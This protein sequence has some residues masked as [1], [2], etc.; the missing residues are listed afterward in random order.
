MLAFSLAPK[1]FKKVTSFAYFF[2]SQRWC[3]ISFP[4]QAFWGSTF[5]C[6]TVLRQ[7]TAVSVL[8]SAVVLGE[9]LAVVILDQR[10]WKLLSLAHG[11]LGSF[12]APEKVCGFA[13]CSNAVCHWGLPSPLS[14]FWWWVLGFFP[15][16]FIWSSQSWSSDLGES[17]SER[18][19]VLVFWWGDG[20][21]FDGYLCLI[22]APSAVRCA[23]LHGNS[24]PQT[25]DSSLRGA[26]FSSSRVSRPGKPK[27]IT[28]KELTSGVPLPVL[29]GFSLVKSPRQ[30]GPVHLCDDGLLPGLSLKA[31][32]VQLCWTEAFDKKSTFVQ[33]WFLRCR[34]KKQNKEVLY[35]SLSGFGVK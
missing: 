26:A 9:L 21:C 18:S 4:L 7:H 22:A 13:K 15:L 12:Q 30:S 20:Q 5:V 32:A 19:Q 1:T 11:I 34:L 16:Q 3:S 14:F 27:A 33:G 2:L 24:N 25:L 6:F 23:D 17:K 29:S 10:G 8:C 31:V 35:N 28:K